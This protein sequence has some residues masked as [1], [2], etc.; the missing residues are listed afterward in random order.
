MTS[1]QEVLLTQS[2]RFFDVR[3]NLINRSVVQLITVGALSRKRVDLRPSR[4][5]LSRIF[6]AS[7]VIDGSRRK[8][9]MVGHEAHEADKERV[10]YLR[11][12]CKFP[13]HR[14]RTLGVRLASGNSDE[15]SVSIFRYARESHV[16]EVIH[17]SSYLA[18]AG[19]SL[20]SP[21]LVLISWLFLAF[22]FNSVIS[23]SSIS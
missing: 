9:N 1:K 10:G 21:H 20:C 2:N 6:D 12:P 15:R 18:T 14:V 22:R 23:I 16:V 3:L 19:L 5:E 17:P 13:I 8:S 11:V 7:M 4:S